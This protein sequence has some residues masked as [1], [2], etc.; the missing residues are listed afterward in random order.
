MRKQGTPV[1]N[2]GR[3]RTLRWPPGNKQLEPERKEA[4]CLD[5]PLCHVDDGE[6]AGLHTGRVAQVTAAWL[7]LGFSYCTCQH[8]TYKLI[9][10]ESHLCKFLLYNPGFSW[11]E[12]M[13]MMMMM[14]MMI[15]MMMMMM[16]IV[17]PP[18]LSPVLL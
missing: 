15:V 6:R 4:C 7:W 9:N 18:P 17:M 13:M 1:E 2:G 16:M 14:M 10:Y 8:S 12:M 5:G 3:E 11:S